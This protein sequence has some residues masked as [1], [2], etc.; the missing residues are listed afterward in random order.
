ME[1]ALVHPR[2]SLC[3]PFPSLRGIDIRSPERP[4]PAL[5]RPVFVHRAPLFFI[6]E[7]AIFILLFDEADDA[8]SH[9]PRVA[10]PKL[11]LRELETSSEDAD[12]ISG[13]TN[14]AGKTATTAPAAQ[15]FKAKTLFVPEVVSHEMAQPVRV[16]DSFNSGC[17][18]KHEIF[19]IAMQSK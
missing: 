1:H 10:V 2:A 15:A 3:P 4:G 6:K 13:D 8:A 17:L 14:S 16:D 18:R 7:D 12:L 9:A 5:S 19:D 11:G